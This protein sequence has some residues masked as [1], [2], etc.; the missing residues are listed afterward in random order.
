MVIMMFRTNVLK[1]VILPNI[2]NTDYRIFV[3]KKLFE[4]YHSF[5]I[6]LEVINQKWRIN[7]DVKAYR[8]IHHKQTLDYVEI[9]G[10]EIVTVRTVD[11]DIIKCITFDDSISLMPFKKY[12]IIRCPRITV[13]KA[14]GNTIRY[15]FMNLVSMSHCSMVM[16][17]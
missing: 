2:D 16:V 5:Y 6:N 15:E 13:G 1:E 8:L 14:E 11:D 3:D 7:A 4:V 17:L 9:N 12:D 10:G